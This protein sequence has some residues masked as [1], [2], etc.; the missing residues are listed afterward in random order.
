MPFEARK[1]N[2]TVFLVNQELCFQHISR[3]FNV[4][5]L[6]NVVLSNMNH[7]CIELS[8]KDAQRISGRSFGPLTTSAPGP[9]YPFPIFFS[10]NYKEPINGDFVNCTLRSRAHALPGKSLKNATITG[11]FGFVFEE[12][13]SSQ[14][15]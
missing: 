13:S 7:Q 1:T 15:T 8:V 14:M 11:N 2:F 3:D 6:T 12:N 5:I 4:T 9:S 10:D